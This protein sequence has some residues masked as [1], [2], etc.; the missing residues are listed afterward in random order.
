M[1]KQNSLLIVDDDA[2]SLMELASVLKQDYKIY[3]V[4]DG[5]PA[6]EKAHEALP[7]LIL[8]DVIMQGMNGF[9]VLAELKKSEKTKAIPVIFITGMKD[10]INES[11]GLTLGAVDYIRKPFDTTVV[12]LRVSQQLSLINMQRELERAL[13]AAEE[14]AALTC[15][16]LPPNSAENNSAQANSGGAGPIPGMC[17]M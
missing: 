12:K 11:E 13:A 10:S 5:K 17:A 8:L 16:R 2:S 4:K 9:E 15:T 7:D 3:A 6:L 14:A 1:D